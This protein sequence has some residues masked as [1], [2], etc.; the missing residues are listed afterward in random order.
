M[1]F[2]SSLALLA[3]GV[4]MTTMTERTKDIYIDRIEVMVQLKD[5]VSAED[6]ECAKPE[7]AK[8][9]EQLEGDEGIK[10]VTFRN[11]Q[12]SYDRFVELFQDSDPRLVEQT[13]KDAFSAAF[14]VR[15]EDPTDAAPIDAVRDNP[16]VQDVVDQGEDLQAATRNLDSIRNAAFFVAAVQAVAA[17]FLIVNMVQIAA[18]SRREEI[19]I[20]RMVGASRWY[21]QAPFVLEAIIGAVIGAVIAVGGMLAGKALVVDKA[22]DSVYR[23]NL[24]AKITTADIWLMA[25]I[26]VIIGAAVAA[27]TAQITLRWYVKN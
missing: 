14:H 23:A 18:Y 6:P 12:Q 5:E 4:L 19:S 15:L 17:I 2:R 16:V 13:S 8:L 21:T 26:L 1:L 24:V 25:P 27:I 9:R 22:L 10:S 11:K 7:C 3:T 20:M